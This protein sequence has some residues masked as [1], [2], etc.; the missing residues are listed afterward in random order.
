LPLICHPGV[1]TAPSLISAAR[2]EANFQENSSGW[3]VQTESRE[4]ILLTYTSFF[5]LTKNT[6]PQLLPPPFSFRLARV[7]LCG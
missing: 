3:G 2:H 5:K 1:R 6:G 4:H 7:M